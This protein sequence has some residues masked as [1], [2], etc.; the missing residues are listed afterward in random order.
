[1]CIYACIHK[2]LSYTH[3]FMYGCV[4]A[5]VCVC[6]CVCVCLCLCLCVSFVYMDEVKYI[7]I[8]LLVSF[9]R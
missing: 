1:M 3:T 6:M 8:N 9:S 7:T 4:Y 2:L 5:Y